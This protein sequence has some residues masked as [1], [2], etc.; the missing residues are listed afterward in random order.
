MSKFL[1]ISGEFDRAVKIYLKLQ[2]KDV[3]HL[4]RSQNLHNVINSI[5][6]ELMTLDVDKTIQLLIENPKNP[7]QI[8]ESLKSH[9][10]FLFAF[11]EVFEKVDSSG[12]FDWK[13]IQLCVKHDRAKL[14]PLLKRSKVYP[15]QEAFDLCK[16]NFLHEEKIYL[17]DRMGNAI[18]ALEIIVSELKD[19]KMAI[20]FCREHDDIELWEFL[21]DKS[22]DKSEIVTLLMDS[23]SS[24]FIDP[25]IL[26]NKIEVDQEIVGLKKALITMLHNYETQVR[27]H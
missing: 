27:F 10:K 17:L 2:N 7:H 19:A 23:M 8:V 24:F 12:E 3:F 4:I 9:E 20:K 13:L 26:I 15:L 11:L 6:V 25:E 22:I 1:Q 21:I 14:L 18:E 5:I 16:N